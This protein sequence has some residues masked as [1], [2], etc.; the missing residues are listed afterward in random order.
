MPSGSASLRRTNTSVVET[1]LF[2]MHF[3]REASWPKVHSYL[4]GRCLPLSIIFAFNIAD[5][6]FYGGSPIVSKTESASQFAI[7]TFGGQYIFCV[8]IDQGK[9]DGGHF[10][11]FIK[12]FYYQ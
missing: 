4:F 2:I 9:P 5:R 11:C 6:I 10:L 12:P 7:Y 3:I 8:H 1:N